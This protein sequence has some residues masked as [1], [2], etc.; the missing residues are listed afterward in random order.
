MRKLFF[1]LVIALM[2]VSVVGIAPQVQAQDD[3]LAL[4]CSA[5]TNGQ[6]LSVVPTTLTFWFTEE[7]TEAA[8]AVAVAGGDDVESETAVDGAVVTVTS[9]GFEAGNLYAVSGTVSSDSGEVDVA[10]GFG[11]AESVF[12]AGDEA[13]EL[14][15][16]CPDEEMDMGDETTDDGDATTDDADAT[17]DDGDATTDDADVA[18]DDAD[19]ATDGQED[20]VGESISGSTGSTDFSVTLPAE[21]T[22]E[23]FDNYFQFPVTVIA[24]DSDVAQTY[25]ESPDGVQEFIIIFTSFTSED[26]EIFGLEAQ[27]DSATIIATLLRADS[28][29]EEPV[30][31]TVAGADALQVNFT[32]EVSGKSGT[33]YLISFSGDEVTNYLL[34]QGSAPTDDWEGVAESFQAVVDSIAI[35]ETE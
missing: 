31:T 27:A 8:L 18:T 35:V 30:A 33:F 29:A 1:L 32:N 11:I 14:A 26:L 25:I 10:F 19:T 16:D 6:T 20:A 13:P 24:S 22:S 4:Q 21:Y 5:P 28:S 23:E 2:A 7:V 34:I 15:N 12:P 3:G 17:A 9:E